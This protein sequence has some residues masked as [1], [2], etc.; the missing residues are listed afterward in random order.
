MARRRVWSSLSSDYQ[1]RLTR[2]GITR[3]AYES[4]VS[5]KSARG[6]SH[7]PEHPED[8][9]KK[10][11]NYALYR[12]RAA[13]LQQQVIARKQALWDTRFKYNDIRAKENVM[14]RQPSDDGIQGVPGIRILKAILASTDDELEQH[15]MNA[16]YAAGQGV[17]D[18]W[19]ALF[20]H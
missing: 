1:T 8:A 11:S 20:Y 6:H 13:S 3:E 10:P 15:V 2:K 18:D 9:V 12:Q 19:N 16:A 17:S 5:L 4:G 14:R 7:T